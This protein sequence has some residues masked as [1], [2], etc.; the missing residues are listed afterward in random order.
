MA[1][2]F[3]DLL[4]P[5]D[6]EGVKTITSIIGE[7]ADRESYVAMMTEDVERKGYVVMDVL[8]KGRK[9]CFHLN[10]RKPRLVN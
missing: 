3:S 7:G 9:I 4:E 5:V 1:H 10:K 8:Y 2:G 6:F